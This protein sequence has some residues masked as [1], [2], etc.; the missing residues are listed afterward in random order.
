MPLGSRRIWIPPILIQNRI[1][2]SAVNELKERAKK[3]EKEVTRNNEIEITSGFTHE[4]WEPRSAT[5]RMKLLNRS[6][7]TER[8]FPCTISCPAGQ[9]RVNHFS[10]PEKQRREARGSRVK[11]AVP[12]DRTFR[13]RRD[14]RRQEDARATPWAPWVIWALPRD[15]V[16][17]MFLTSKPRARARPRN[18]II[19]PWLRGPVVFREWI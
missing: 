8:H 15:K 14:A 7:I 3:E 13:I 10:T 16:L 11:R 17:I 12:R 4:R 1:Y 19:R 5:S 6:I 18:L 2:T 9:R